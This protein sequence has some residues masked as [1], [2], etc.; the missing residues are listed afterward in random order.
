MWPLAEKSG[1]P[2]LKR[3][4]AQRSVSTTLGSGARRTPRPLAAPDKRGGRVL[5]QPVFNLITGDVVKLQAGWHAA[6]TGQSGPENPAD[7]TSWLDELIANIGGPL[8]SLLSLTLCIDLSTQ[9]LATPGLIDRPPLER[10]AVHNG[11]R[12]GRGLALREASGWAWDLFN[13]HTT[14]H[15]IVQ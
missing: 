13:E 7:A 3:R 6:P 8:P 9:L 10:K 15:P 2:P 14:G 11:Y 1:L 4:H 5:Y 12:L